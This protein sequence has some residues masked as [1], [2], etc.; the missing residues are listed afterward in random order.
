M[1]QAFNVQ[2][3]AA[4]AV[5]AFLGTGALLAGCGIGWAILRSRGNRGAARH[6][7]GAAALVGGL[8][9][10]ALLLFSAGSRGRELRPG[11]EKYFCEIDCHLAYSVVDAA[12]LP[13][14]GSGA[15]AREVVRLRVRFD[16]T[17]TSAR[18]GAAALYPN[19]RRAR[20]LGS[21]GRWYEAAP[22][23]FALASALRSESIDTPLQPGRSYTTALVFE[24]PAGVHAQRL[25]LTESDAVTRLLIGHENSP[26][27]GKAAFALPAPQGGART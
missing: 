11:E 7:A 15:D 9:A 12:W 3:S 21:D 4:L 6:V 26:F 1:Q 18:R 10:A 22:V 13:A 8:Y 5:L 23:P 16:P 24:L 25:V 2:G 27:H 19:P 14:D 17:T 20:A